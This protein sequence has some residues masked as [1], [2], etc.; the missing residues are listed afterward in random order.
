[1]EIRFRPI[2]ELLANEH[3]IH[4]GVILAAAAF[5]A[6]G[7]PVVTQQ[8]VD[9]SSYERISASRLK[10]LL[11]GSRMH[12]PECETP[13]GCDDVFLDAGRLRRSTTATGWASGSYRIVG[14]SY[15]TRIK[16]RRQCFELWEDYGA[17][18]PWLRVPVRANVRSGRIVQLV[19]A[20]R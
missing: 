8:N 6:W 3:S 11:R 4:M 16:G 1:M 20:G 18:S 9:V 12:D 2:A 19:P 5:M 15:C 13:D 17:G 14:N 7:Q 10:E